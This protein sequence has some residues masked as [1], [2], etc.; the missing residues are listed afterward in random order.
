M[1]QI[2]F[3]EGMAIALLEGW[4][5]AISYVPPFGYLT[6]KAIRASN[7]QP[8]KSPAGAGLSI[9][10][11]SSSAFCGKQLIKAVGEEE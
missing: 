5:T 6:A 7:N 10:C 3:L 2:M 1:V 9:R 11:H 4:F 8:Q